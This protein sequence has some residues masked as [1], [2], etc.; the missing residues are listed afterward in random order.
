MTMK[1][2]NVF[3]RMLQIIKLGYICSVFVRLAGR[4][5]KRSGTVSASHLVES[6][7][8]RISF[9]AAFVLCMIL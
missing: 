5:H 9:P 3:K 2:D 4:L 1:Q 8:I 7:G 6:E